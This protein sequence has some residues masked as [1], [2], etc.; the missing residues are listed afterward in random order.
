[1]AL[2]GSGSVPFPANYVSFGQIMRRD[3]S[4][5]A[6]REP[7]TFNYGNQGEQ[8]KAKYKLI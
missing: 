5:G 1:M 2:P 4:D 7:Q 6:C 3:T 8:P